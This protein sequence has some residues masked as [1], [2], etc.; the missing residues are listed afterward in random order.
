M[1][2]DRKDTRHQQERMAKMGPAFCRISRM[3]MV[4]VPCNSKAVPH[5][6]SL[7]ARGS[8]PTDRLSGVLCRSWG[9]CILIRKGQV[10]FKSQ[11]ASLAW[12]LFCGV[13]FYRERCARVFC[14]VW[15]TQGDFSW[16][17]RM[18]V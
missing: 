13:R 3:H 2:K 6:V 17:G 16:P 8:A 15:H 9:M 4:S 11:M 14:G 7:P 12:P 5:V 1:P 18:G 10:V